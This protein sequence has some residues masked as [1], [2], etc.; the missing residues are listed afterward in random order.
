MAVRQRLTWV[1]ER[2]LHFMIASDVKGLLY[3]DIIDRNTRHLLQ[4]G[5]N[6]KGYFSSRIA[7]HV[8]DSQEYPEYHADGRLIILHQTS[9][10]LIPILALG[11]KGHVVKGNAAD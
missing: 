1:V 11:Y 3:S 10:E 9:T 2:F 5:I 4:M 8:I 6:L 7:Y